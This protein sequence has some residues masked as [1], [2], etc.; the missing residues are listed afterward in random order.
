MGSR[1]LS[2]STAALGLALHLYTFVRH[3]GPD[4]IWFSVG[5]LVWSCLPYLFCLAAAFAFRSWLPSFLGAGVAFL[6]DAATFNA[7]F[8][9]PLHSTAAISLLWAPLYNLFVVPVGLLLGW[10]ISLL[11]R[12]HSVAAL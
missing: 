2:L 1:I 3:L 9:H 12:A 5:L 4:T 8:I 11:I 10:L 7:V 6:L